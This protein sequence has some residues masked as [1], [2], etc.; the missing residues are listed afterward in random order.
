M[1]KLVLIALPFLGGCGLF[2]TDATPAIAALDNDR[3]ENIEV[4]NAFE[5]V[6]R[7]APESTEAERARKAKILDMIEEQREA[8]AERHRLV[9]EYLESVGEVDYAQLL[10]ELT[11]DYL[12]IAGK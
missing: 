11:T 2:S 5:E 1:K 10:D 7:T 3:R 9:R 8:G 4:L 12:R 6:V